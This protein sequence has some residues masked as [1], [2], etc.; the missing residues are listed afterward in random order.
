MR[1]R[2]LGSD[3]PVRLTPASRDRYIDFLRALSIVAVVLGHWLI[4][5]IS[6]R[7]G[8]IRE[9]SAVGRVPG[10]WAGTWVFQVM[11]IFF[12]VGGFA[13]LRALESARRRGDS[14]ASFLQ[15][16]IRRLLVP[17]VPF[18]ATW[19]AVQVG[20]H[21]ADVGAA[22]G[23]R[24]WGGTRML[25]GVRPP[26]QT[27]PFGP[28]WFLGAYLVVVAVSPLTVALHRRFRWWVPALLVAGAVTTDVIAFPGGHPGVRYLNCAFVL[29]A[30]HQFGHFHGDGS[31][32]QWSRRVAW[33]LAAGGFGG[34][35]VLTNPWLYQLFGDVRFRWFPGVGQYPRSL[36]GT[37]IES[38]SNAFP[39]T[40]C[41]L[42]AGV[43]AVGILLLI[44]PT[45]TRWLE[46]PAPWRATVAVNA[47][48]MTVFLWHMTAYLLAI[49]VLW[50]FGF[51]RERGPTIRWWVERPLWIA[52]AGVILAGLVAIFGRFEDAGR[53]PAPSGVRTG[54]RLG[55]V[56]ADDAGGGG[57]RELGL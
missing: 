15:R 41:F 5:V 51:G 40:V 23:P 12:Y 29:L 31:A 18:F 43:W 45:V 17:A 2:S 9:T 57:A 47:R 34:L 27:I 7:R 52:G 21:L 6:W 24:L 25:R 36:L 20:L 22:T 37:D 33:G 42:L 26:A 19:T 54:C 53:K 56:V 39:P 1:T 13:N 55:I 14:I 44:R 3:D 11:P 30:F 16:R 32:L 4:A 38:I 46:R 48:I 10:L 49:L 28:L 50:P 8:L 35:V